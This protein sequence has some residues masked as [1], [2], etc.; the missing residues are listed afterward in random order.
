[1]KT[2]FSVLQKLIAH[3]HSSAEKHK[4]LYIFMGRADKKAS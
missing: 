1:M 3:I 2:C 4:K